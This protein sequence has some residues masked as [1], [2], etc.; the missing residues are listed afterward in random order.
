MNENRQLSIAICIPL[1][2][3][4]YSKFFI[5][6]INRLGEWVQ[7]YKLTVLPEAGPF[8]A[9]SRCDLVQKALDADADYILFLDSDITISAD[10]LDKLVES[11]KDIISGIYVDKAEPPFAPIHY[12]RIGDVDYKHNKPNSD[13]GVVQVDGIGLGCVLIRSRVFKNEKIKNKYP[14]F[15]ADWFNRDG[16]IGMY[17]EDFYFCKLVTDAG[18]K[19]YVHNGVQCGHIGGVI[20]P[21]ISQFYYDK[22]MK[23]KKEKATK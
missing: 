14:W 4:I 10:A 19:I 8:L 22:M 16:E 3:T 20:T 13:G 23:D 1:G 7:K 17:G 11:G 21:E 2:S 5:N 15:R 9:K 12:S 18:Y 6:F